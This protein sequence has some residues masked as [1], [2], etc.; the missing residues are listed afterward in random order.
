MRKLSTATALAASALLAACGG[1]NPP[2]TTSTQNSN[3]PA[4]SAQTSLQHGTSPSANLGVAS[5][6]GGGTDASG[7]TAPA[8]NAPVQTP[9]LD[10]KIQKAEAKAKASGASEAD[11]KAAAAA[12]FERADFYR[13]QGS[14]V[15]YKFALRDYRIGLRYDPGAREPRAKMDEIVGIYKG[16]GRPVPELGNE[17]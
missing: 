7:G 17:P 2:T 1:A 5:S 8:M 3:A 11:K 15:L 9:E 10:A 12:Y 6:H 13:D 14:P 16:M 4:N